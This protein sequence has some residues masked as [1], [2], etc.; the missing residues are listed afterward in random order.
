MDQNIF[1]SDKNF[2]LIARHPDAA[3]LRKKRRTIK[4]NFTISGRPEAESESNRICVHR[5]GDRSQWRVRLFMP[6][7]LRK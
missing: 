7:L 5:H 3:F 1:T 6:L 2:S 4:T